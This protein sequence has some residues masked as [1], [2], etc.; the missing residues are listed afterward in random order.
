MPEGNLTEEQ[1]DEQYRKAVAAYR[2]SGSYTAFNK[3]FEQVCET[4]DKELSPAEKEKLDQLLDE[5]NVRVP[6]YDQGTSNDKAM[7]YVLDNL[8]ESIGL[9]LA[10]VPEDVHSA[11][12]P[13]YRAENWIHRAKEVKELI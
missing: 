6:A 4:L 5:A 9:W 1:E 11:A 8:I 10:T 7:H 12:L 3:A 13:R 2:K